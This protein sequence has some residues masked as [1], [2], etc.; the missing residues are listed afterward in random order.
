MITSCR[1]YLKNCLNQVGISRVNTKKSEGTKH[2]AVPYAEVVFE[3]GD[4]RKDG[5]LVARFEGPGEKERTFRR[6]LYER[7]EL[8]RVKIVHR[9]QATAETTRDEFISLLDKR[10]DDGNGNAVLITAYQSEPEEEGSIL[11]QETAAYIDARFEGG[12]FKDHTV[13]LINTETDLL[14]DGEE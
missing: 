6:R 14:I 7:T 10:I 2:Q 9:D 5:R 1:E 3:E 8:A 11:R 12:L 4:L 13:M